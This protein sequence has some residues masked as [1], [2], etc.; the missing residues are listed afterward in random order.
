M[1]HPLILLWK[2][3]A[4]FGN[5][6]A[7]IM[8]DED[9]KKS[10]FASSSVENM[11]TGTTEHSSASVGNSFEGNVWFSLQIIS[12]EIIKRQHLYFT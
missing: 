7:I 6:K 3:I 11:A 10:T 9:Q 12:N 4:A 5:S 8:E 1:K 2:Q